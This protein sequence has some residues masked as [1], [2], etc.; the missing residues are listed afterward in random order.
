MFLQNWVMFRENVGKY[1]MEHLDSSYKATEIY[2]GV[3][4]QFSSSYH[5][6]Y[7]HSFRKG[8]FQLMGV[9]NYHDY[10]ISYYIHWITPAAAR[11][12]FL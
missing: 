7:C 8:I 3:K 11:S 4:L 6:I 5:W 12:D 9:I 1:T 10:S 2:L